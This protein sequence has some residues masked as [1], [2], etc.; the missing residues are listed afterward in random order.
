MRSADYA[1]KRACTFF[2]SQHQPVP[3]E[4]LLRTLASTPYAQAPSDYYGIGGAVELLE[5]RV[6]ALLGKSRARFFIKGVTAQLA[7]LRGHMEAA[8]TSNIA[9]HPQS[10]LHVDEG[11]AIEQVAGAAAIRL[12]RFRPFTV[13]DLDDVTE[14]LAAVV[15]ELPLRRSG[16]LLPLLEDVKAI[17]RWCRSR[18]IALHLDGARL[19][20][21]AAGYGVKP[22]EL[23]SLADTIYVS[24]YKGL[25]GLGG[26]AIVGTERHCQHLD[27]WRKR[28]G[29]DL[30]TAFPQAIA[31]LHGLDV[32]LA[33][34]T[35]YVGRARA[36]AEMLCTQLGL[37]INPTIPHTNAFQIL[38]EGA[39]DELRGR[40]RQFAARTGVWLFND[41]SESAL[42]G[43]SIV[44]IVIGNAADAYDNQRAVEWLRD[45][46]C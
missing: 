33:R 39:P 46:V 31:A 16:Y 41:V 44:E 18:E 45:F 10:H 3:P 17:S 43:R 23:A 37:M 20:E 28:F 25:G 24:F 29:G 30:F 14:R 8:A 36:L 5:S 13:R 6:S 26:A 19:W 34:M 1:P 11:G 27:V 32:H 4:T 15:L 35:E 40:H 22:I 2:L 21:A 9:I 7:C 38:L 12:G 42:E